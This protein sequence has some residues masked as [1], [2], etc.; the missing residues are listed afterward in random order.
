M[1]DRKM[2]RKD[3]HRHTWLFECHFCIRIHPL[4]QA[5][6]QRNMHFKK[7]EDYAESESYSVSLITFIILVIINGKLSWQGQKT[8]A[9]TLSKKCDLKN[10]RE[11][12][13]TSITNTET[14]KGL[15]ASSSGHVLC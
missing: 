13:H 4:R 12:F 6:T 8:Y 3:L 2:L 9:V 10:P 7:R 5:K 1:C 14:Q 15:S 11:D